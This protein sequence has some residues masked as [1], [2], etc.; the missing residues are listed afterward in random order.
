MGWCT[1]KYRGG[2]TKGAQRCVGH[3][4]MHSGVYGGF[5][6]GVLEVCTEGCIKGYKGHGGIYRGMTGEMCRRVQRGGRKS[7]DLLHTSRHVKLLYIHDV[8]VHGN[9]LMV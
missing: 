7:V 5:C 1:E 6:L 4:G 2:V 9:L 3:R 8:Y